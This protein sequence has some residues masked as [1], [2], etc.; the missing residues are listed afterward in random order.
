LAFMPKVRRRS[1]ARMRATR[2]SSRT[3]KAIAEIDENSTGDVDV[4]TRAREKKAGEA[5]ADEARKGF[6]LLVV[7]L[8]KVIGEKSGFDKRIEDV[9]VGFGRPLA[10]VVAKASHLKPPL[11]NDFKILVPVSGSGVSR[12]GAEIAVALA[13][14]SLAPLRLVE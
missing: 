2:P 13:R 11:T 4:T 1:A 6:D 12:R 7:G 14:S 8:D 3:R 10:I 5:V 9:T